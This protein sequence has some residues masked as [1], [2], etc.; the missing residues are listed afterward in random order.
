MAPPYNHISNKTYYKNYLKN[1]LTT[2]FL[3]GILKPSK[4]QKS[5]E[6]DNKMYNIKYITE[7]IEN[8]IQKDYD[9]NHVTTAITMLEAVCDEAAK[10]G[11]KE[12][13]VNT[14]SMNFPELTY[15]ELKEVESKYIRNGYEFKTYYNPHLYINISWNIE[16][17]WE[18]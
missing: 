17:I 10:Q 13:T 18:G 12:C 14:K 4:E 1:L 16:S 7:R 11:Y 6:G 2:M 5:L 3:H 8:T 9:E 15:R